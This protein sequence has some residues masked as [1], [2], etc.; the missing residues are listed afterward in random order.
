[1]QSWKFLAHFFR[2][3]GKC[4]NLAIDNSA[5]F[6]C[7]E[8]K[9]VSGTLLFLQLPPQ[10]HWKKVRFYLPNNVL[11]SMSTPPSP[12]PPPFE[13]FLEEKRS[14]FDIWQSACAL[15][16]MWIGE[17]VVCFAKGTQ[18]SAGVETMCAG[19]LWWPSTFRF[20]CCPCSTNSLVHSP[21]SQMMMRRRECVNSRYISAGVYIAYHHPRLTELEIR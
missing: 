13:L 11:F 5:I 17:N 15:F 19:A 8:T 7:R 21:N 14:V 4:C 20:L 16:L 10:R 3:F 6:R 18:A 2:F 12:P 1:M 9:N